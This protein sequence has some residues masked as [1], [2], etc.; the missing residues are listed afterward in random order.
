M[1][2]LFVVRANTPQPFMPYENLKE[3]GESVP[4]Y[5]V[6][7]FGDVQCLVNN[8]Q[9]EAS[10]P[11]PT[12]SVV[13]SLCQRSANGLT[14]QVRANGDIEH[15]PDQVATLVDDAWSSVS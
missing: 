14:V 12:D 1:A 6:K 8:T 10:G 4:L 3:L 13:T 7:Q 2:Q 5:E 15:H 11:E 9:P